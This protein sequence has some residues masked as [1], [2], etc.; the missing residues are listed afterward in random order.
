MWVQ[1]ILG[2]LLCMVLMLI[3]RVSEFSTRMLVFEQ[4]LAKTITL[5]ELRLFRYQ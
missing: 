3:M 1:L 5:D 4:Y 2:I